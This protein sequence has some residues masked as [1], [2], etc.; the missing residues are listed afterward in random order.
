MFS[1]FTYSGPVVERSRG[2]SPV[3]GSDGTKVFG[4]PFRLLARRFCFVRIAGFRPV[5]WARC[6]GEVFLKFSAIGICFILKERPKG[7]AT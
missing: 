6:R 5:I 2:Y 1:F 4:Q 3:G 7:S